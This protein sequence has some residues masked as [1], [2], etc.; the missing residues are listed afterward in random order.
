MQKSLLKKDSL[1]LLSQIPFIWNDNCMSW[2]IMIIY[3]FIYTY[4]FNNPIPGTLSN[5]NKKCLSLRIYVHDVYD[6]IVC[7]G[8][9]L[10]IEWILMNMEMIEYIR[11]WSY[12]GILCSR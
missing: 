2:F 11:Y 1:V 9:K 7:E 10:E 6:S 5:R 8:R 4:T 12:K 3:V